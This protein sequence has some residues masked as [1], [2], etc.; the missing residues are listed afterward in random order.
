MTHAFSIRTLLL[1]VSLPLLS[2]CGAISALNGATAALDVYE[3]RVPADLPVATGRALQRDVVIELPTTGGALATDRIMVRPSPLQAQYLPDVRWSEETPVMVQTLMLRTLD[4]T[5]GLRYVGRRPLGASGDFAIVSELVDFQADLS[6]DAETA[7]VEVSMIARIVRERD[8]AIVAS[9]V[10]T[11]SVPAPSSE[12]PVLVDAFDAAVA[13]V[14]T[15]FA[16]WALTAV[17]VN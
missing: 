12:T 7:T 9:R 15:D 13:Q 11:A 3:L 1:A 14:M 10:F 8:L 16:P 6:P 17:R 4:A 2:G 5:Q